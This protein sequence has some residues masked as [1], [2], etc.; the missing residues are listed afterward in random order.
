MH[1]L[2]S[3]TF[4]DFLI[5]HQ[6]AIGLE[7]WRDHGGISERFGKYPRLGNLAL[8][9]GS[10]SGISGTGRPARAIFSGYYL[11]FRRI[12]PC[13]ARS[14][15]G[16]AQPGLRGTGESFLFFILYSAYLGCGFCISSCLKRIRFSQFLPLV[17]TLV[18]PPPPPPDLYEYLE[19]SRRKWRI[20]VCS[21]NMIIFIPCA[22]GGRKHFQFFVYFVLVLCRALL[23][24]ARTLQPGSRTF[25]F[26]G[27][28]AAARYNVW[29]ILDATWPRFDT[30]RANGR[31]AIMVTVMVTVLVRFGRFSDTRIHRNRWCQDTKHEKESKFLTT[32]WG[33]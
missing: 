32:N 8:N 31:V 17:G 5:L 19:D 13:S 26:G 16:Y 3:A 29:R 12:G 1:I 22:S 9:A 6:Y 23:E 25:R 2:P 15:P 4:V 21:W 11:V 20:F 33:K 27:C 24:P 14:A 7:K 30:R 10:F 28:H 18:P